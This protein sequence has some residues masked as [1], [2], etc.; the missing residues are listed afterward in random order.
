MISR[1]HVIRQTFLATLAR[2]TLKFL[3]FLQIKGR[4]ELRRKALYFSKPN[5]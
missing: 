2:A 4:F 3:S 1:L 5:V